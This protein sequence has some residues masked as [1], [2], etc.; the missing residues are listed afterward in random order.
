[1]PDWL[2]YVHIVLG[3]GPNCARQSGEYI[4][5]EGQTGASAMGWA[6]LGGRDLDGDQIDDLVLGAPYAVVGGNVSGL[7]FA[8]RGA[9]LADLLAADMFRPLVNG[10]LDPDEL[11][12]WPIDLSTP[13]AHFGPRGQVN[14]RSGV[15]G[16]PNTNGSWSVERFGSALTW[17]PGIGD[18]GVGVA[19]GSHRMDIGNADNAGEVVIY[20]WVDDPEDGKHFQVKGRMIG[21]TKV[22]NGAFGSNLTGGIVNDLPTVGVG[23][24]WASPQDV[25]DQVQ[26]GAGYLLKMQ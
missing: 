16:R 4:T 8:I 1:M 23:A 22:P 5:L 11:I 10:S 17:V 6:M 14:I 26:N 24:P 15:S 21:D 18:H 19:V 9:D 12:P 25:D 3:Y 7:F 2:G 20:E 13:E